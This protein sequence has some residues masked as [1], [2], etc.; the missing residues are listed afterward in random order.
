MIQRRRTPYGDI[1]VRPVQLVR[2]LVKGY[3]D[4]R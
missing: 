4:E 2:T 1:R 3:P